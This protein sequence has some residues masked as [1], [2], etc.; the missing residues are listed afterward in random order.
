MRTTLLHS[1]M[2][3]V[4]AALAWGCGNSAKT[5]KKATGNT[6][7]EKD[8]QLPG[9]G[10]GIDLSALEFGPYLAEAPQGFA[11]RQVSV[12]F[13]F[14]DVREQ[15]D[16]DKDAIFDYRYKQAA[17]YVQ[18][19]H[20]P[21]TVADGCVTVK[22]LAGTAN[23]A[24]TVEFSG[25]ASGEKPL[26]GGFAR[27]A[28]KDAETGVSTLEPLKVKIK[29][30]DGK[31]VEIGSPEMPTA[32]AIQLAGAIDANVTVNSF[33]KDINK[34]LADAND[35]LLIGDVG[36]AKN[37]NLIVVT[38]YPSADAAEPTPVR[39]Y[40]PVG[41]G[42]KLSKAKFQKMLPFRGIIGHFANIV[43]TTKDDVTYWAA[44]IAGQGAED[45][46]VK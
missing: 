15:K 39:C 40:L 27:I 18:D 35:D 10:G 26:A 2:I 44:A 20:L 32:A 23:P 36:T 21:T 38:F 7:K 9:D 3:V 16:G 11:T 29:G 6:S 41:G 4:A 5:E 33:L 22:P 34:T 46:T 24:K 17:V 25:G 14:F 8:E 45:L 1:S 42:A 37:Y 19:G 31:D 43:V 28:G 13:G 30:L 12:E